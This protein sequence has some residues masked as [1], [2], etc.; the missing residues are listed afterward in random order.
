MSPQI[1]RLRK[2]F[3]RFNPALRLLKPFDVGTG[4]FA[5]CVNVDVLLSGGKGPS[6]CYTLQYFKDEK[7]Y[8]ENVNN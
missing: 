3:L 7:V 4:R 5:G 8:Q 2:G 6:C 1:S